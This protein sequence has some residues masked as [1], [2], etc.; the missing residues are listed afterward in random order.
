MHITRHA[1]QRMNQRGISKEVIKLIFKYGEPRG[2]RTILGQETAARLYVERQAEMLMLQRQVVKCLKR[3]AEMLMLQREMK[4]LKKVIDKGGVTVIFGKKTII[5][6]E[7]I[8]LDET[9]VITTYNDKKPKKSYW[10]PNMRNPAERAFIS[11]G[12]KGSYEQ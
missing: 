12:R 10:K 9:V 7:D 3:Q 5:L 1:D 6:D 4:C 2:D 11:M 8:V